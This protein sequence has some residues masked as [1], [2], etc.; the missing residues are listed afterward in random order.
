VDTPPGSVQGVMLVVEDI[1]AAHA[2]LADR[3]VDVS[4]VQEFP[5]GSFVFFSDP[6]GNGWAVQQIPDR[7]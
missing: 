5:W 7:T 4:E 3:G 1:Q 2:E 6:D